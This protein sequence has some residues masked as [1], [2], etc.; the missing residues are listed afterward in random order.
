MFEV[1][2]NSDDSV[3]SRRRWLQISGL[4]A[5]SLAWPATTSASPIVA[6]SR[7]FG[8]AKSC[9]FIF[10]FGG[11]GQQDLWDL[12]PDAPAERRGEFKPIATNAGGIS[13]SDHLPHLS[14]QADKFAIV[15][16]VSHKDFEHG[17][18]SYTALT[19]HPHP[20]PGTNSP[21][22][23]EDFP[24]FG[25]VIAKRKPTTKPI[26]SAVVLG[27]VMHQGNRPPLAG[28]NAG[29]FGIAH[30][31]FRITGDPNAM[32]FQVAGLA[33]PDDVNIERLTERFE[34]LRS[35]ESTR[36]VESEKT[37]GIAQLKERAFGLLGSSQSQRAFDLAKESS[38]T[39]DQYGRHQ[40]GQTMLLARRLVEAE[41]PLITINWSKLNAD[42]WDTHKNN[43]A[44]LRQLLP[45]YDQ[46]LAA[47]LNDLDERGLLDTTLVVSLGEFGRTP[48]INENA[49]RDHWPD[50][51]S[52]VMAGGGIKRGFVLGASDREAAYPVTDPVAP[53]D[54][55]ATMYHLLGLNPDMHV[56]DRLNRPFKLSQGR[57][58]K[59]LI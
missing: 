42:Q 41:V 30:E 3:L 54:L 37:L 59:D 23:D 5:L 14:K 33:A 46:G 13:I 8:K 43:Y 39:R 57:V 31:P 34:F 56:Y 50:C 4:G 52:V 48:K 16:S 29:F 15:R 25:A 7:G 21:A 58:V 1:P 20:L 38:K 24:T 18:A 35:L 36:R 11:P 51:Y 9:V 55:A 44:K 19:G 49:G 40:F 2:H 12:K 47:F 45:P 28:Q 27:P 26:P 53:W 22:T 32:D 17:S 10:Q 6:G